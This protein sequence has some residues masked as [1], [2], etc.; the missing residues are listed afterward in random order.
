MLSKY[1]RIQVSHLDWVHMSSEQ[2]KA[3]IK[4]AQKVK[5]HDEWQSLPSAS[6]V[7]VKKSLGVGIDDA[8]ISHVSIEKLQNMWDKA[9]I[10]KY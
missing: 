3:K 5:L 1:K 6:S 2:R 4:K 7:P 10:A 9:G 8:R